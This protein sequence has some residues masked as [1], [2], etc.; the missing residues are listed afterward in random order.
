MP[1]LLFWIPEL[2]PGEGYAGDLSS[3]YRQRYRA[4][5]RSSWPS[6]KIYVPHWNVGQMLPHQHDSQRVGTRLIL[7]A[8]RTGVDVLL[9]NN[10]PTTWLRNF[11]LIRRWSINEHIPLK[12]FTVGRFFVPLP[13]L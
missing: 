5:G 11:S 9:L 6:R 10:S 13:A 12:L 7:G 8:G 1:A 2:V 4:L 3:R